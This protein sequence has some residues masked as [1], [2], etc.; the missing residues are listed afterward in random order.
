MSCGKKLIG[1]KEPELGNLEKS[2]PINIQKMRRLV[3]KTLR[4]WPK[5]RMIKRLCV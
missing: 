1:K 4:V 3:L 2:Q 5:D